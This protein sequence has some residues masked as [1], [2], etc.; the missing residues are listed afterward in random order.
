MSTLAFLNQLVGG[1]VLGD[2]LTA[3]V[4]LLVANDGFSLDAGYRNVTDRADAGDP[5]I[6]AAAGQTWVL[7]AD[8]DPDEAPAKRL[9]VVERTVDGIFVLYSDIDPEA[10]ERPEHLQPQDVGLSEASKG[11]DLLISVLDLYE[12]ES[13]YPPEYFLPGCQPKGVDVS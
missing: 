12:L 1:Q 4:N 2:H 3:H 6:L 7:R 9:T 11:D 10:K 8:V 5:S 13:W